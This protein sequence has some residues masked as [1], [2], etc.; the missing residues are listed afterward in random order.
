M[1]ARRPSYP[2]WRIIEAKKSGEARGFATIS[3]KFTL[4]EEA[5]VDTKKI[6]KNLSLVAKFQKERGGPGSQTSNEKCPFGKETHYGQSN[7][8]SNLSCSDRCLW[9][10]LKCSLVHSV[11]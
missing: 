6:M 3:A 2:T 5:G 1:R 4:L 8:N 9:L 7:F 10:R 11:L